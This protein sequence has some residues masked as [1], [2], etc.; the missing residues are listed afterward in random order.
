MYPMPSFK[1][2]LSAFA[3]AASAVTSAQAGPQEACLHKLLPNL[4]P[5]TA[6]PLASGK[7]LMGSHSVAYP[8]V[9]EDKPGISVLNSHANTAFFYN[10]D[11]KAL[12]ALATKISI[13]SIGTLS[14]DTL[15]KDQ[16]AMP[17]GPDIAKGLFPQEKW[18]EQKEAFAACFK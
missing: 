8:V 11:P 10:I 18:P 6:Q 5:A 15:K 16:D 17:R 3:L 7:T 14:L 1:S 13:D 12:T 2:H 4:I 9:F